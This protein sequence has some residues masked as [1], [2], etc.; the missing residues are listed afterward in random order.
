MLRLFRRNGE[1]SRAVRPAA[2]ALDRAVRPVTEQLECR[3]LLAALPTPA[4][5]ASGGLYAGGDSDLTYDDKG[6]LHLAYYDAAEENLKYATRPEGGAW[7]DPLTLDDGQY[8][9]LYT[10]VAT[11]GDRIAVS[12]FDGWAADLKVALFDG[13]AWET[14]TLD[15]G[16]AG[17]EVTGMYTSAAFGTGGELFVS[18]YDMEEGDLRLAELRPDG[19]IEL[20]GAPGRRG[21][22]DPRSAAGHRPWPD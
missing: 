15:A 2:T 4:S 7:S 13:S 18:Y 20:G 1:F 10:D 14:L 11:Q 17:S 16:S 8:A 19:S 12:Y 21:G 3:R 22:A 5:F 6:T 9:G